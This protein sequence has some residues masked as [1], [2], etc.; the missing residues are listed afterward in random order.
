MKIRASSV[1][2]AAEPHSYDGISR[3]LEVQ[4]GQQGTDSLL[5]FEMLS[6]KRATVRAQPV[7]FQAARLP[8]R[9]GHPTGRAPKLRTRAVVDVD[10]DSFE[11]E[12]VKVRACCSAGCDLANSDI[13]H[14][15]WRSLLCS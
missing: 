12:I 2:A 6:A 4:E 9:S 1:Q 11:S 13:G 3:E 5:T 10:A 14:V 15:N 8:K 7:P